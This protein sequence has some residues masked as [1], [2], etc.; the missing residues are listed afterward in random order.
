MLAAHGIVAPVSAYEPDGVERTVRGEPCVTR[1]PHWI[2]S[3][4]ARED[5]RRLRPLWSD[6]RNAPELEARVAGRDR[7]AESRGQRALRWLRSCLGRSEDVAAVIAGLRDG[8][9]EAIATDHAPHTAEE[10][11]AEFDR[12]PFGIIGLETALGL[13]V[14]ELVRPGHIEL[15]DVVRL[16]SVGPRRILGVGGS[17]IEVGAVAD[18][19]VWNPEVEWV[20]SKDEICSRSTNSPFYGRRLTGR[21]ALTV[22]RGKVTHWRD[23]LAP[24]S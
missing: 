10:K 9:L 14:T 18:L 13:T 4:K 15:T 6:H 23:E 11:E 16:L 21:S 8:T 20:V 2:I 12:A 7:G 3:V 22:S 17:T 1:H 24:E 5:L 19:T